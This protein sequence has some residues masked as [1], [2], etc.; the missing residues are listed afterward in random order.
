MIGA[1]A[2][3]IVLAPVGAP[4]VRWVADEII[5]PALTA[6]GSAVR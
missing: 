1:G 5:Q 6:T 3:H 2:R 4:S